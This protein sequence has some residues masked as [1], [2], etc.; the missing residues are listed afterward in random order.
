MGRIPEAAEIYANRGDMLKAVKTLIE[1]TTSG[2]DHARPAIEYLLAGLRN[3]LTFG[4]PPES[5]P[6]A[7]KLL[8]YAD[9]LE[10]SVMTERET[11]EASSPDSI[12]RWDLHRNTPSS[13][14]SKRFGLLI[15]R[16]SAHSPGLSLRKETTPLRCCVWIISSRTPSNCGTA[17]WTRSTPRSPSTL[18]ISSC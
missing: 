9:R 5:C 11:D 17:Q 4:A 10:K 2:G 6:I 3:E 15:V 13:Q 12:G 18:I 1:H 16:A 8:G 14:C 7:S